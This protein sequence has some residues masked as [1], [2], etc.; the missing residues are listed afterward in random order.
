MIYDR[1]RAQYMF[2]ETEDVGPEANRFL[3]EMGQHAQDVDIILIV[4]TGCLGKNKY[5]GSERNPLGG[6]SAKIAEVLGAQIT[7]MR[8]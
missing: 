7:H 3:I 1:A 4:A 8:T 5:K 6:R 2:S